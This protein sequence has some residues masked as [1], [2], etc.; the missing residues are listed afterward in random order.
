MFQG[1]DRRGR[2]RR[3]Y[4]PGDLV[5]LGYY[6]HVTGCDASINDN[7]SHEA[8]LGGRARHLIG[9]YEDELRVSQAQARRKASRRRSRAQYRTRGHVGAGFLQ[10][11]PLGA[12]TTSSRCVT[13]GAVSWPNTLGSPAYAQEPSEPYPF[14]GKSSPLTL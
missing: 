3:I 14:H 12:C 5:T 4:G 1:F 8:H 11:R 9:I 10:H 7:G 2:C 13:I 6:V